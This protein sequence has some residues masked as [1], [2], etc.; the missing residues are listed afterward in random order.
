MITP[1]ANLEP[2]ELSG[3]TIRRV[4]LHNF[5]FITEK[6]IHLHDWIRLQRSG[7]VIPYIVSVISD[8]R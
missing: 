3:V 6:D 1:V 7:E 2:V 4:S 8:R 5:D